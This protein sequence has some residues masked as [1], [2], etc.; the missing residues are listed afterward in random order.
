[1]DTTRF[2]L[3]VALGALGLMLWNAWQEDYGQPAG[4]TAMA[5]VDPI[6]SNLSAGA[7]L[8]EMMLADTAGAPELAI[9]DRI[10]EGDLVLLESD[11]LRLKISSSGATVVEADL[12][13]YPVDPDVPERP[14]ALL[15]QDPASLF[16]VETGLLSSTGNIDHRTPFSSDARRYR[17]EDG[18]D[19][20]TAVFTTRVD[21]ID[22]EKRVTLTRGSYEVNV[23][24]LVQNHGAE[25]WV[26]RPY[27]QLKRVRE[28]GREGFVYTFTGAALSTPA[29]H[30]QKY[31]FDKLADKGIDATVTEGWVAFIQHYFLAAIVPEAGT[32]TRFYSKS[33]SDDLFVVGAVR[34][35][36]QVAPGTNAGA[37]QNLVI[38][39]KLQ[40]RLAAIAPHLEL[41]VD[42]GWVWFIA[43]PLFWLL[44]AIHR[45]VG[46][47]GIA[48]ILVTLLLKMAL[49]PLSAAGYRSMARMRKLQPR[50]VALK[51]RFDG[52]RQGMNQAMMEM[53]KK[54]KV[55]PLGGCFPIV[56]QIPV[57]L[58][59]YWVLLESVELRQAPFLLWIQDLSSKDP[60]FVLPLLM[61]LSMWFQQRLNPAPMDPMQARVMQLMPIIMTGFFAFFP[62]G[63]VLYWVVNNVVSIAQQWYITRQIEKA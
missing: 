24:Y 45:V 3:I 10:D 41:A 7:D 43:K 52:D 42:Y 13:D 55:N 28:S 25:G 63:L 53:Y 5:D 29:D 47:W 20:V 26:G 61:G 56:V 35:P 11:V 23:A 59:L 22:I 44:D 16:I 18:R 32:D 48:I 40:G 14:L 51:E 34:P 46:N 19:S 27:Y 58:S 8:P 33:V 2:I 17:I 1:M 9:S 30:Y 54:E 6:A 21:D 31:S 62:A 4:V 49:Y 60:F 12:L 50:L 57:F 36:I 39:P 15:N 37:D 38:G